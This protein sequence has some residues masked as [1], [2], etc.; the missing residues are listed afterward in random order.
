MQRDVTQYKS[1]YRISQTA[2]EARS[3]SGAKWRA[4]GQSAAVCEGR[5]GR[6]GT[7]WCLRVGVVRTNTQGPRVVVGGH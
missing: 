7:G 6:T 4:H 2:D 1:E 3:A 5:G